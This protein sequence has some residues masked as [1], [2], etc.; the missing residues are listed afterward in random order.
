MKQTYCIT[1]SLLLV[2]AGIPAS[3]SPAPGK[4]PGHK[5]PAKKL[6]ESDKPPFVGMTKTQALARYGNPNSKTSTDNGEQGTEP[7]NLCL[8]IATHWIT[9]VFRPQQVRT[10]LVVVS[11]H[12]PAKSFAY[13][14]A[15]GYRASL[16]R[17]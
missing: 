10:P 13:I 7:A 2:C 1:P 17:K 4:S 8:V 6:D 5:P 12:G 9:L 3:P 11:Q 15:C 14:L 16:L